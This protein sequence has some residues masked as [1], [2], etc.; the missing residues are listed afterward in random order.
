LGSV[1]SKLFL[2]GINKTINSN[3]CRDDEIDH[4]NNSEKQ[5]TFIKLVS[6]SHVPK[7]DV[8]GGSDVYFNATYSTNNVMYTLKSKKTYKTVGADL[9]SNNDYL[10]LTLEHD[11]K[12]TDQG[13]PATTLELFDVDLLS[14]DDYLGSMVVSVNN[15]YDCHDL[16]DDT[17]IKE[18][19]Y[20]GDEYI[21]FIAIRCTCGRCNWINQSN[22]F[23]LSSS[24]SLEQMCRQ[25]DDDI[26]VYNIKNRGFEK[27]YVYTSTKGLLYAFYVTNRGVIINNK[28]LNRFLNWVPET[29]SRIKET[30]DSEGMIDSFIKTFSIDPNNYE[31]SP[32][33]ETSKWG[34]FGDFFIRGI[35]NIDQQRPLPTITFP[36][37]QLDHDI[38]L[39]KMDDKESNVI[40]INDS[41]KRSNKVKTYI[42]NVSDS[43]VIY[44]DDVD[45]E[46]T[47]VW[48][49]GVNFSIENMLSDTSN[50]SDTDYNTKRIVVDI[51]RDMM[52]ICPSCPSCPPCPLDDVK[53]SPKEVSNKIHNLT[54]SISPELKEF[55][56]ICRSITVFRLAPQDYHRFHMPHDGRL[57]HVS[58]VL[59]E[60]S[61][62]FSVNPFAVNSRDV[63]VF[64]NN[65]RQVF[66]FVDETTELKFALVMVGATSVKDFRYFTDVRKSIGTIYKRGDVLGGFEFGSTVI[67]L[68]NKNLDTK[69]VNLHTLSTVCKNSDSKKVLESRVQVRDFLGLVC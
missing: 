14:A 5:K 2:S 22:D 16:T 57:T 12:E 63:S 6:F 40:K 62:L 36:S 32:N 35:K 20:R 30:Y 56:K 67:L 34:T 59:G 58:N 42:T 15:V 53:D 38:R 45:L 11:S 37:D 19:K 65:R 47:K 52:S 54:R 33:P 27:E 61:P 25:T 10:V 28:Y 7:G 64:I 41:L 26:V 69:T 21:K 55:A 1:S 49:K 66:L 24:M 13:F 3:F 31:G 39:E 9:F 68:M 29:I 8:T 23:K 48:I 60:S 18:L 44:F 50:H 51:A 46:T 43:R 17:N 4:R